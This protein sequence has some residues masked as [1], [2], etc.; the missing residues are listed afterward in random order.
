MV[1]LDVLIGIASVESGVHPLIVRDGAKL[2]IVASAGE[3]VS[4]VLG[5]GERGREFGLGLLGLTA[6][7]LQSVGVPIADAFEPCAAMRAAAL[8]MAKSRAVPERAK[9][10]PTVMDKVIIRDWWRPDYRFVSGMAYEAAV[11]AERKQSAIGKQEIG[12]E[13]PRVDVIDTTAVIT[14][15]S[16]GARA[17]VR[18]SSDDGGRRSAAPRETPAQAVNDVP[19]WDVFGRARG[20]SVFVFGGK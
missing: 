4:F 8:L 13:L 6:A 5:S 3:G 7:R 20:S 15:I 12:G 16:S 11:N 19:R 14:T 10:A 18:G 9:Y 17:R 2:V 1:A